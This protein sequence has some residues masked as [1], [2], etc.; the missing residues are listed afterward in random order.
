MAFRF[1]R[2]YDKSGESGGPDPERSVWE[3]IMGPDSMG[4]N[5]KDEERAPVSNE[6]IE[7][8]SREK[9]GKPILK[10]VFFILM[11]L[12][13]L[14][15]A[16]HEPLLRRAGEFL[17][18]SH[19]LEKADL[20]VCLSGR[21][22][23]RGLAT[24][25]LYKKGLAAKVLITRELPPD[26][27]DVLEEAGVHIPETVDTLRR[28]LTGMGV[29]EED[30]FVGNEPARSTMSEAALVRAFAGE[31]GYQSLILVTSP[32]HT[33]RAY[34][35]YQKEMEGRGISVQMHATPFS[36]FRPEDW[37]KTRRYV[38]EVI[39]EYQKLVFYWL[40]GNAS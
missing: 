31:K 34:D 36:G 25:E 8:K 6:P 24:A 39:V 22:V 18:V 5:D 13:V 15:S 7:P 4:G 9:P 21:P 20:L 10:W 38:K 2:T 33:R 16:Y 11:G 37:W 14:L 28:I 17:I 27:H 12:W 23:E 30:I 32:T 1:G 19:D 40:F 3:G 29:G 35:T 26:G